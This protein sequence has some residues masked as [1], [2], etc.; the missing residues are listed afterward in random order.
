[1]CESSYA[2]RT[3]Q[4][5]STLNNVLPTSGIPLELFHL[6][7]NLLL[8]SSQQCSKPHGGNMVAV[9][10]LQTDDSHSPRLRGAVRIIDMIDAKR[11]ITWSRLTLSALSLHRDCTL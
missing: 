8:G 4:W 11:V 3:C 6:L 9:V 5:A 10:V 2:C 7:E 1:M